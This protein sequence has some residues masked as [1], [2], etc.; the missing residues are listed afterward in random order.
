MATRCLLMDAPIQPDGPPIRDGL[1]Y[2]RIARLAE[3]MVRPFVAIG[4]A[5][6]R[7]GLSAPAIEASDLDKGLLLVEDLGNRA[8]TTEV[9]GGASQAELWRTAVDA[10]IQLR[11]VPVPASLPLPDGSGHVLPRRDRAAFEI[12]VELLLDWYWPG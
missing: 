8:F 6:K 2:S 12:E 1:S 5:L 7:A 9:A 3:N 10:L 4:A 11:G